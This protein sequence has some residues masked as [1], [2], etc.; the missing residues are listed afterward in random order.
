MRVC[1][2]CQLPKSDEEFPRCGFC[3]NTGKVKRRPRCNGCHWQFE[4]AQREK[5]KSTGRPQI[6]LSD[7]AAVWATK[8]LLVT[9]DQS[10]RTRK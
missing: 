9:A 6:T 1:I 8:P 4:R 10:H 3:Q 7:Q 2:E 5:K